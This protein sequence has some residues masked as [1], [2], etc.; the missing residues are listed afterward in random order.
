M[1]L[2][3]HL[4]RHKHLGGV[5]VD[6]F[7]FFLPRQCAAAMA[8]QL[9]ALFQIVGVPLSWKKLRLGFSLAFLGWDVSVHEGCFACVTA[10]KQVKLDREMQVF[11]KNPRKLSRQRLM[12]LLGLLI[13]ATQ[14][15]LTLRS[16]LAPLYRAAHA[17]SQKLACL[18]LEQ[19]ELLPLLNGD[20]EV[21]SS[22]GKSDVQKGWRLAGVGAHGCRDLGMVRCLL[23]QPKLRNGKI[24]LRFLAWGSSVKLPPAAV[25][26][27]KVLRQQLLGQQFSLMQPTS[28]FN[29]AA[30]AWACAHL[31]GLGGWFETRGS[32]MGST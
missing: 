1:R 3:H 6:D 13:W 18:S 20:L 17:R 27:L 5:Y 11:L 2:A 32:Y 14:A 29:G 10:E 26:A 4:L 12:G 9:T 28:Q 25:A 8:A 16:F 19:V 21:V 31:A 7:L 15:R 23:Q 24:W 30:D 22:P